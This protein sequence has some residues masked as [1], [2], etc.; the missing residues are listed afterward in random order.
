MSGSLVFRFQHSQYNSRLIVVH[1]AG[2]LQGGGA[3]SRAL[4]LPVLAESVAEGLL[5]TIGCMQIESALSRAGKEEAVAKLKA[6]FDESTAVFAVRFNKIG[7][8]PHSFPRVHQTAQQ[9]PHRASM[10]VST[11]PDRLSS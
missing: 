4:H 11:H 10:G 9:Q 7:V 6:A 8:S 2:R 1:S 5:P 3:L